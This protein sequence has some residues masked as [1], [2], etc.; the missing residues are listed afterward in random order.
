MMSTQTVVFWIFVLGGIAARGK[1]EEQWFF[2]NL[3]LKH[4]TTGS[5]RQGDI[6]KILRKI[7]WSKDW[8]G[9]LEETLKKLQV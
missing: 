6:E 9:Y 8:S 7:L 4:K 5:H 2:D 3:R 1:A